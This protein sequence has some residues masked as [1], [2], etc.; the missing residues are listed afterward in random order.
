MRIGPAFALVLVALGAGPSAHAATDTRTQLVEIKAS[1]DALGLKIERLQGRNQV[2]KIQRAYG[3]YVD[4]AQWPAIADM[5]AANGTY[6][7]GGR[8][9]FVGPKRVLEYLVV[10][11]GPIGI[12]T[13]YNQMID[14]QQFQG[15]VN[16]SADGKHAW[17]RWTAFVMSSGGWGDVTYSNEYVK[18]DG[19][20]K[21]LHIRAPF[22]MYTNYKDGWE[23]Y[24]MQ[25][26]WPNKFPPPPD[27]P[28]STVYLTYPSFYVA[29]YH[30]P[31]PVT[32]RPM[33]PPNPAAGGVAPMKPVAEP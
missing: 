32:G 24:A 12:A 1:L 18:E 3:Y 10:G 7:I 15:L 30:Y 33:P 4:K 28:P 17:G 9:I 19:V 29:P 6:E 16:V 25:N 27:L 21:V 13:R 5:F 2:E 23:K 14:H 31:N 26:T 22:N 20:W 8:G 11:L